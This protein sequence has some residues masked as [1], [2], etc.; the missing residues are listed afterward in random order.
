MNMTRKICF[1]FAGARAEDMTWKRELSERRLVHQAMRGL[2]CEVSARDSTLRGKEKH[3]V[4]EHD[5]TYTVRGNSLVEAR[6]ECP[7]VTPDF[8]KPKPQR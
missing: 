4:H 6:R 7:L 1:R 5:V 8:D 3:D 2:Y